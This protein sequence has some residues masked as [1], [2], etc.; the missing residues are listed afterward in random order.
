M[1]KLD[2]HHQSVQVMPLKRMPMGAITTLALNPMESNYSLAVGY[3]SGSI[4]LLK[5][6]SNNNCLLRGKT[7]PVLSLAFSEQVC[8]FLHVP[9]CSCQLHILIIILLL[10]LLLCLFC[11]C[12]CCCILL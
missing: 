7:N 6:Q 11:C 12:C 5:E 3:E 9:A 2:E 8:Y 10:L 1:A 4:E